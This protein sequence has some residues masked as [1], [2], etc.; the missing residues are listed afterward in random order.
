MVCP[1]V[2]E[3]FEARRPKDSAVLSRIGGLVSFEGISKGKRIITVTDDYGN[4]YKHQVPMGPSPSGAKRRSG[5]GYR[6]P[7]RRAQRPS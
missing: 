4:Q 6:A 5:R 3:L 1:R 2:G 7:V